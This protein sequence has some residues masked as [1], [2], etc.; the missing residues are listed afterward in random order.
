[1]KYIIMECHTSYAV[2]L[3]EEGRFLKVANLH[4]EVG[5]T[6][7][8][9]VEMKSEEVQPVKKRNRRL[10]AS[11][12]SMAACLV[13]MATG[14]FHFWQ[15][16]YGSVY[17]TINPEIRIDLN[18]NH[19]V[20]DIRGLNEDGKILLNGYDYQNKSINPAMDELVNRS[21]DMGFLSEHGTIRLSADS[22]DK[23]WV[24]ATKDQLYHHL[25]EFLADRMEVAIEMEMEDG[26]TYKNQG[27]SSSHNSD[28]NESVTIIIP[29]E[30]NTI[31]T[32]SEKSNNYN[33]IDYYTGNDGGST[34]YIEELP[35][36]TS[37][38]I[39]SDDE[40]DGDSNDT[41]DAWFL[42]TEENKDNEGDDDEGN[43]VG[44]Y[45][46]DNGDSKYD[47]RDDL[48]SDGDSDYEDN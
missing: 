8:H 31:S 3:D 45:A 42:S 5:K 32:E 21:I 36:T 12:A 13:L 18:Q 14:M 20:I 40:D 26:G 27:E 2:A 30:S 4:Y 43:D 17:I 1:M 6:V 9:V 33:D 34:D 24:A 35:D 39:S 7:S 37:P 15:L 46:D 25:N 29:V 23:T 22:K 44:D 16:P 11:I 28:A 10:I 47:A 19:Q 38:D 41:D 48:K